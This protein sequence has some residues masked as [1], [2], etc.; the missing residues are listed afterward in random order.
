V[1]KLLGGTGLLALSAITGVMDIN[2]FILSL[3]QQNSNVESVFIAAIL[4]AA[5][6]NVIMKG[7]Y[8]AVLSGQRQRETLIRYSAWAILHIPFILIG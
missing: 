4:T 6:S 1:Q 5:M 7:I 2:P 3:V 8:F